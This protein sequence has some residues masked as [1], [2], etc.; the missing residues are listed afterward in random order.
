MLL[1]IMGE[2]NDDAQMDKSFMSTQGGFIR[3]V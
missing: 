2:I 3:S 1:V